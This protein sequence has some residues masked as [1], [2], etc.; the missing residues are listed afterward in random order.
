MNERQ[1]A[2]AV[3]VRQ[4]TINMI[5]NGKSRPSPELAARIE[6]IT[7]IPLRVLLGVGAEA[8]GE[9]AAG[10]GAG[11]DTG[12][13]PMDALAAEFKRSSVVVIDD[14]LITPGEQ[15]ARLKAL[16]DSVENLE[17]VKGQVSLAQLKHLMVMYE[18]LEN[19]KDSWKAYAGKVEATQDAA[20]K[21]ETA[22]TTEN[23]RLK[24]NRDYW[25]KRAKTLEALIK[26]YIESESANVKRR[27][28]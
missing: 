7:G 15:L 22:L 21:R 20:L 23:A 3:G 8:A 24:E 5:R 18:A 26:K 6:K 16:F 10:A 2:S 11:P 4:P 25:M 28:G 12:V 27:A 1:L 14:E 17:T 9:E 13:S 19:E